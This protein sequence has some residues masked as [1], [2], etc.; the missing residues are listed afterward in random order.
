MV[1]ALLKSQ[2]LNVK[3]FRQVLDIKSPAVT[4]HCGDNAEFKNMVLK[5]H[6]GTAIVA[7]GLQMTD[8]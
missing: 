7:P 5:V 2:Q 4:Q 6:Y 1:K 3:I 8:A